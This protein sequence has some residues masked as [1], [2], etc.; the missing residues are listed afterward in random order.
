[1][2]WYPP[3]LLKTSASGRQKLKV[4]YFFFK[5]KGCKKCK[6]KEQWRYWQVQL[7]APSKLLFLGKMSSWRI[8][9]PFHRFHHFVPDSFGFSLSKLFVYDL[10]K[11]KLIWIRIIK[12]L[13]KRMSA[14]NS[15]F[16]LSIKLSAICHYQM[17][18][19]EH[20][21]TKFDFMKRL[22]ISWPVFGVAIL[23]FHKK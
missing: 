3:M 18:I 23:A 4:Y 14:L 13:E 12:L 5:R 15:D 11:R 1:M 19:I 6:E 10:S 9:K 22:G 8:W 17:D 21:T 20:A 16:K 2:Q 7:L